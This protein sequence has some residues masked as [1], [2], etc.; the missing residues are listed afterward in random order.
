MVVGVWP[1]DRASAGSVNL[2]GLYVVSAM[3]SNYSQYWWEGPSIFGG[4]SGV[5]YAFMGLIMATQWRR[6]AGSRRRHGPYSLYDDL[7]RDRDGRSMEFIGVGAHCQQGHVGG[8]LAGWILGVVISGLP[9]LF[10][11]R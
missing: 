11:S 1:A 10:G 9:T 3:L 7:A 4:M 8:L 5:V 2:L 6:P